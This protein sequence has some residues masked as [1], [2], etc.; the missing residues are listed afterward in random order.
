MT[1][2]IKFLVEIEAR[3][4][5]PE[6]L[7]GEFEAFLT[8]L[9]EFHSRGPA[10]VSVLHLRPADVVVDADALL[11]LQQSRSAIEDFLRTVSKRSDNFV[12]GLERL[13]DDG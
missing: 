1:E 12:P 6:F 9:V 13:M 11:R 3:D 4:P 7:R 10:K 2:P 5:D 8:R